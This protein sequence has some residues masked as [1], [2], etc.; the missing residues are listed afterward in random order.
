M[1]TRAWALPFASFSPDWVTIIA[2][3]RS[4]PGLFSGRI[5][6]AL[7][8][9]GLRPLGT[10]SIQ[11]TA[12]RSGIRVAAIVRGGLASPP[13]DFHKLLPKHLAACPLIGGDR[14]NRPNDAGPIEYLGNRGDR[15]PRIR[16]CQKSESENRTKAETSFGFA[17]AAWFTF[18]ER[19]T[20]KTPPKTN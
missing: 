7:N 4:Q 15:V 2:G 18:C 10:G 17:S 9:T 6:H 12:G 8:A 13:M 1:T 19:A 11:A 20:A 14:P 5:A 3:T 16:R